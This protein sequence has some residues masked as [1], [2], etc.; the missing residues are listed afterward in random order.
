MLT[1][2]SAAPRRVVIPQ[3]YRLDPDLPLPEVFGG[4]VPLGGLHVARH[5][6][7]FVEPLG[8]RLGAELSRPPASRR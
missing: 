7:R 4:M 6:Q 3:G 1:D 2:R 8:L 5:L